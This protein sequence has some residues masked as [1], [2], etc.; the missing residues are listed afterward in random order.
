MN[1][2]SFH[3]EENFWPSVSDMFLTLFVIALALYSTTN[4]DKGAGDLFIEQQ[5]TLAACELVEDLQAACPDDT[6][7]CSFN[8]TAMQDEDTKGSPRTALAGYVM[9]IVEHSA[10]RKRFNLGDCTEADM[11]EARSDY[12]KAIVLAYKACQ[13][14]RPD[15]PAQPSDQI[16]E[17]RKVMLKAIDIE[18]VGDVQTPEALKRALAEA[19]TKVGELESKLANSVSKEEYRKLEAEFKGLQELLNKQ[20]DIASL[21][22]EL[23]RAKERIKDL[24]EE[25][26]KLRSQATGMITQIEKL[27][28]QLNADT[29]RLVMQDARDVLIN[30]DLTIGIDVEVEDDLGVIRIPSRSVSFESGVFK[31]FSG[32]RLLEN[33][34]HA[35]REIASDK[36]IDN[37]VIECHADTD[38]DDFD[39]EVLSSNRA[40]YIW[41]Y[42][43]EKSG[44]T[45][46][47][48]KNSSGLGLFS[49]AGFGERVPMT[50]I[51][52]ESTYA[53]KERCRRIDIRF[54]CAPMKGVE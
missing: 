31:R 35:L 44:Y 9:D 7:I 13:G 40:L 51:P 37:I 47:T 12:K 15:M 21:R 34:A 16:R 2:N 45:L 48:F 42:L 24:E 53:Y 25:N 41:K 27:K 49:H 43:N 20:G 36:R 38:G 46:Q 30:H 1:R 18:N 28:N 23:A 54:N 5:A 52:G 11:E 3:T 19:L 6:V 33:M 14:T 10:Q 17:I 26:A 32:G 22:G 39:N 50:P 29:R 4:R 8:I